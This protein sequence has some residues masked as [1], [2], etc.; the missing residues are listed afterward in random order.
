M[1][2][3]ILAVCLSVLNHFCRLITVN[4]HNCHVITVE[5]FSNLSTNQEICF[6]HKHLPVGKPASILAE[7]LETANFEMESGMI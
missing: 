2:V 6:A 3:H 4:N 7:P 1:A 5:N